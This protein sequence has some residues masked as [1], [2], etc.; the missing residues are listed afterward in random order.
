MNFS[1]NNNQSQGI[2]YSTVSPYKQKIYHSKLGKNRNRNRKIDKGNQ[3]NILQPFINL[4]PIQ[5]NF[6]N[7]SSINGFTQNTSNIITN[8]SY[9]YNINTNQS[10]SGIYNSY[11]A[12]PTYESAIQPAIYSTVNIL[13]TKYYT[14]YTFTSQ[15]SNMQTVPNII[16]TTNQIEKNEYYMPPSIDIPSYSTPQVSTTYST[17]QVSNYSTSQISYSTPQL[18]DPQ[19]STTFSTPQVS[20]TY[21]T[22]QVN[23]TYSTPQV[24]NTYSTPQVNT[25]YSTEQ[26]S[27]ES[28]QNYT[29]NNNNNE[30]E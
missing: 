4:K 10:N 5:N 29:Y 21:S 9:N 20:T 24:S 17:P 12:N 30:Y 16:T 26:V 18:F 19:V 15:E 2:L 27:D 28:Q 13:P 7:L 14:D 1:L 23:T 8:P 25:T 22:P 3:P 11:I 6:T